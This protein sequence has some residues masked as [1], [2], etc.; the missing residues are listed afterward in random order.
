MESYKNIIDE[1]WTVLNHLEEKEIDFN[2]EKTNEQKPEKN[3]IENLKNNIENLKNKLNLLKKKKKKKDDEIKIL[4]IQNE[5][6]AKENK[7]LKEKLEDQN[8]K[9]QEIVRKFDTYLKI[10]K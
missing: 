3:I 2:D 9:Y 8:N 6:Y 1:K 5:K 7:E 10:S 4:K